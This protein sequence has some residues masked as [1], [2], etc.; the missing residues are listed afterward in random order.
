MSHALVYLILVASSHNQLLKF[1]HFIIYDKYKLKENCDSWDFYS[2][3]W[4]FKLTY[5]EFFFKKLSK[6]LIS[7][8]VSVRENDD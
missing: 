4:F 5:K 7:E 2:A 1:S 6:S 3:I 8:S